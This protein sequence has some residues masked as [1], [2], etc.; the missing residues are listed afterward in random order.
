MLRDRAL[1]VET[2]RKHALFVK[3]C[4]HDRNYVKVQSSNRQQHD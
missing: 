1:G 2:Q 3:L 4:E